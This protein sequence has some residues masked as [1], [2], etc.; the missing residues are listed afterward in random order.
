L[1]H[2]DSTGI[3]A[4]II[5]TEKLIETNYHYCQLHS[6][7]NKERSISQRIKFIIIIRVNYKHYNR[8]Q[9]TACY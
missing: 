3:A 8:Q 7:L 2:Q 9:S 5:A 6:N 1:N 4:Q